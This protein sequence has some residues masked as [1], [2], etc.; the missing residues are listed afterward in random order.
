M[1]CSYKCFIH[2][3]LYNVH[4]S[5]L[6]WKCQYCSCFTFEK[7]EQR[8]IDMAEGLQVLSMRVFI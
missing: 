1:K 4:K 2:Y 3:D 8:I 5:A 7:T 6:N